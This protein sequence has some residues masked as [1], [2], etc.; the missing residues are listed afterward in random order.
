[1]GLHMHHACSEVCL[2]DSQYCVKSLSSVIYPPLLLDLTPFLLLVIL[3][4]MVMV[5]AVMNIRSVI[6][7]PTMPALV[8]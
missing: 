1:M 4:K 3:I 8:Q 7:V 6:V 2:K 5:I